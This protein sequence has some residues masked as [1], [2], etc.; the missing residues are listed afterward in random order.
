MKCNLKIELTADFRKIWI[1]EK[2]VPG[3]LETSNFVWS[4]IGGQLDYPQSFR[5]KSF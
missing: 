1:L 3:L 4:M 2:L 5:R